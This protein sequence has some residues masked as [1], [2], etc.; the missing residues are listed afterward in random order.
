L[1]LVIKNIF[2]M[3]KSEAKFRIEA[4]IKEI[5]L[6]R[7]NYHI[8][9]IDTIS[10]EILDQLKSELSHLEEL[11]PE[12]IDPNSPTQ[13]VSGEV[14]DKFKKYTHQERMFS[15][16]DVFSINELKDW[17]SKNTKLLDLDQSIKND[18]FCEF[19]LDGLAISLIYQNNLLE[20]ASTRGNGLVGENVTHNVK[21]VHNIPLNLDLN[22]DQI[23]L[24]L[25]KLRQGWG[26]NFREKYN[27]N[28]EV[29]GEVY[30]KTS[31][32]VRVNKLLEEKGE[33]TFANPRNLA[34]GSIRQ[35]DSNISADRNLSFF[36][37]GLMTDLGQTTQ[38]E[39]FFLLEKL[40]FPVVKEN[41]LFNSLEDID[42]FH[43]QLF[44]N[45]SKIDFAYDGI[46]VKI[47]N[48]EY[49]KKLGFVGKG[50]RYMIAFKFEAEEKTTI[51]NDIRLQV[52]RTG[53][54]TPVAILEPVEIYGVIVSNATLHN[55]S[56]IDRLDVRI[57]DTVIV[58]RAGDVIPEI[59]SIIKG[60]RPKNT[61]NFV[62]GTECPVC[63]TKLEQK[64]GQIN[65]YCPNLE[66]P[67][68]ILRNLSYFVSKQAFNIVGLSDKILDRL[69]KAKLLKTEADLFK[70]K[71]VDLLELDGFKEK[72]AKKLVE[73]INRSKKITFPKFIQALGI[74]NVGEQTAKSLANKLSNWQDLSEVSLEELQEIKD[75]GEIVAKSIFEYI[76]NVDNQTKIQ[77]LFD[78]GLEIIYPD[79]NKKQGFFT[80]KKVVITGT[81]IEYKREELK[82][83]VESQGGEVLAS[84][85][86]HTDYLLAGEK[87]GSKLEKAQTL[88]V[89]VLGEDELRDKIK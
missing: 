32:F 13:K 16:G 80:D 66:C 6:H 40:G 55:Q 57:G 24:E 86:N 25:D 89:E 37:W 83:I 79:K 35:L 18:L 56:E 65:L 7:N 1:N 67:A 29:R 73:S 46:V 59:V 30:V 8:K 62:I 52:G 3:N 47:N 17:L 44:Q 43:Q 75:I 39:S 45:R 48:L 23:A 11:Y 22:L 70:L 50:P 85:S 9:D 61:Q 21:T 15:L 42:K 63:Q 69:I 76:H 14:L 78:S 51:V 77:A 38:Q 81:F 5:N 71:E 64:E 36:A 10:P 33:Q 68:R 28:I 41:S 34:A 4:L 84:V 27:G 74:L 2:F 31:D 82:S 49:Q 54:I 72:S 53:K 20:I 12:Y 26:L 60:L 19:K 87:A 58:R 88:G